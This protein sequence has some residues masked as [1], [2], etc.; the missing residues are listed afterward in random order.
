MKASNR[1]RGFTLIELLVVISIIALLIGLLLPALSRARKVAQQAKDGTQVRGLHQG[2]VSWAQDNNERYPLPS[3]IDRA[4]RTELAPTSAAQP[5]KNRTGNVLSLMIFNQ[6][7][8]TELCV[9][10]A[11]ASSAIRAI[12]EGEFRYRNPTGTPA[13]EAQKAWEALWDP[14]FHGSP[15][16][17]LASNYPERAGVASNKGVGNNSY[18]HIPLFGQRFTR[19]W[20]SVNQAANAAIWANRGPVFD[21][22]SSPTSMTSG[23]WKPLVGRTGTESETLLIHGTK[24]SWSGNVVYNDGSVR[25]EN[26]ATPPGMHVDERLRLQTGER[27]RKPD[28]IFFDEP[29]EYVGEN[30]STA[31]PGIEERTNTFLRIWHRGIPDRSTFTGSGQINYAVAHLG[32]TNGGDAAS[33]WVWVDGHSL[34]N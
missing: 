5:S 16:D 34:G 4:N 20:S 7:I 28:N 29:L 19:D 30:I 9:S 8:S 31:G 24:D 10:P 25:F 2:C 18:A 32:G 3:L 23:E 11:E 33:P 6:V 15:I 1:K 17:D 21:P 22:A 27:T 14:G 12:R 26:T 13:E